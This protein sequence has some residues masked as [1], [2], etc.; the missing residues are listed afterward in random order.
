MWTNQ[1]RIPTYT[2]P[3]RQSYDL[4]T[5]LEIFFMCFS[6][7]DVDLSPTDLNTTNPFFPMAAIAIKLIRQPIPSTKTI[8][9]IFTETPPPSWERVIQSAQSELELV[10]HILQQLGDFYPPRH[11][12]LYSLDS[13]PLQMVKIVLLGQDPYHGPGQANGMSFSVTRGVPI[14]P[15][16]NNIFLEL[17]Q[18]Y[19]EDEFNQ[20]YRDYLSSRDYL[21]AEYTFS[22]DDQLNTLWKNETGYT[23]EEHQ[24]LKNKSAYNAALRAKMNMTEE[25]IQSFTQMTDEQIR[26]YVEQICPIFRRP[27]HGDLTAWA[28]QGVLLLNTCLTVKPHEPGSHKQIWNGVVTRIIDAISEENP[29]C[30]YILLGKKAQEFGTKLGQRAIRLMASHPSPYS[31]RV[32]SR[33]VPA[34]IGSGIFKAAN[35]MLVKQGKTPIDWRLD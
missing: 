34:F 32:G 31:A 11:L 27:S 29:E 21:R 26:I 6:P 13:C 24:N 15:S 30:I 10:S 35:E 16:L 18:E 7:I 1:E 17:E 12:V 25:Q 4:A 23:I 28:E 3:I 9:E 5:I 19:N 33:D 2:K 22:V 8:F 20:V 14:P